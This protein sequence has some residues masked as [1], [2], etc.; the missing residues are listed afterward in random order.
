MYETNEQYR[1]I[2]SREVRIL[3]ESCQCIIEDG[4]HGFCPRCGEHGTW[5]I[6]TKG[7]IE[8]YGNSIYY[9]TVYNEWRCRICDFRRHK[10]GSQVIGIWLGQM[11]EKEMLH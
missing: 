7:F 9:S 10:E 3:E 6:A 1:L 4:K 8:N 5:D 11:N 2:V